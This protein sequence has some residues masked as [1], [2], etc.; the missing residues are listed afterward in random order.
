MSRRP[1]PYI[2][3][4]VRCM[5]A[6]RQCYEAGFNPPS[7]EAGETLRQ[8]LLRQLVALKFI[9]PQL[10]HDPALI[11]RRFNTST[12]KY[13]PP[14]DDYRHLIYREKA[15]HQQKTTG[16]KPGAERTVTTKGS[17]IGIKTKFARLER[18][19]NKPKVSRFAK[20]RKMQSRPFPKKD[21]P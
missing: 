20:G 2:S 8:F 19:K 15:D 13:T 7:R 6:T 4:Q 11:L 12:G 9:D 3:F 16:R 14:A 10:D 5:V 1:R 18:K 17:D 21:R